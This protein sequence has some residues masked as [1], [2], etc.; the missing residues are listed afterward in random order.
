MF[1]QIVVPLRPK[2][3]V[4][5][6]RYGSSPPLSPAVVLS[7]PPGRLPPTGGRRRRRR[8]SVGSHCEFR[9]PVAPDL[10]EDREGHEERA[11]ST[12]CNS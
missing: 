7:F 4:Y 3:S 1:G 5:L 2:A 9:Q 12:S 10:N 6:R 11:A 8:C